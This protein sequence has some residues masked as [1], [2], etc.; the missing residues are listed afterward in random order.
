M[1]GLLPD[2]NIKIAAFTVSESLLIY[3]L[4]FRNDMHVSSLYSFKLFSDI[5][6]TCM[7]RCSLDVFKI[8]CLDM[9]SYMSA[10]VL[11]N[12]LNG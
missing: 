6:R 9:G 7:F 10:H 2:M 5:L 1:A 11:S 4:F 12:L 3:M 8:T